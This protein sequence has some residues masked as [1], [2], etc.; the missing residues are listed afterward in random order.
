M[1]GRRFLDMVTLP[2]PERVDGR[3]VCAG[4]GGEIG[5]VGVEM[6]VDLARDERWGRGVY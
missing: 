4:S 6:E 1:G 3:F 2:V 5:E